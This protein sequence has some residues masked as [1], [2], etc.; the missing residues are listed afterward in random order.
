MSSNTTNEWAATTSTG[1]RETTTTQEWR[2]G[3]VGDRLDPTSWNIEA[4]LPPSDDRELAYE[5]L[6]PVAAAMQGTLWDGGRRELGE[7]FVNLLFHGSILQAN[8]RTIYL[9]VWIVNLA[10]SILHD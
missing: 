1:V 7:R 8:F 2:H 5:D 10:A 9:A 3:R 6:P 4:V